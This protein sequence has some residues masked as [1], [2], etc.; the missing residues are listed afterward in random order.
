MRQQTPLLGMSPDSVST[1]CGVRQLSIPTIPRSCNPLN[2]SQL[3]S[4]ETE[5]GKGSEN[6]KLDPGQL[7]IHPQA[8]PELLSVHTQ[9]QSG[10]NYHITSDL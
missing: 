9:K 1:D 7:Y 2:F 4:K 5:I 3:L 6:K 10:K 8:Y